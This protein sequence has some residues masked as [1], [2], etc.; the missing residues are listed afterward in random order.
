M[1]FAP[2]ESV[3]VVFRVEPTNE[4][5]VRSIRAITAA[6]L[7]RRHADGAL[8]LICVLLEVAA[9]FITPATWALTGWLAVMGVLA[10]VLLLQGVGR[11]RL[12]HMQANDPHALEPYQIEISA[13][14]VHTWCSHVDARYGWDDITRTLETSEFF[15]FIRSPGCGYTL[16]RRLLT[17]GSETELRAI[18]RDSAATTTPVGA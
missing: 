9:F 1:P 16:P 11:A 8:V 2:A 10:T 14:G 4:E 18:I 12:R 3:L 6:S 7:P 13:Q 15:I 17:D 5:R